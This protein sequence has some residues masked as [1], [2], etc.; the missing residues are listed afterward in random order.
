MLKVGITGGIGTGKT[1]VCKVFST[2]GVPVYYTDDRA[3]WLQ[4]NHPSVIE[5]TKALLGENAYTKE[6][7]LNKKYISNRVFE[8]KNLLIQLNEIVHPAVF[9]DLAKWYAQHQSYAYTLKESALTFE[10]GKFKELDK[11][12]LVTSP[13]ELRIQRILA[14]DK[15]RSKSDIENI[16]KNQWSDE[17]KKA[18]SH[19]LIENDEQKSV[20]CQVLAIHNSLLEQV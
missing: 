14:R 18:L 16:I 8:D 4:I 6:G 17:Q 5:K 3:R 11:I 9:E 1:L 7:Q 13:L 15:H 10:S 12:I 2:L 19:Y 20:I